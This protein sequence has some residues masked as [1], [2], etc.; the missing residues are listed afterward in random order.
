MRCA[1][2]FPLRDDDAILIRIDPKARIDLKSTKGESCARL[3]LL[4]LST[5]RIGPQSLDAN[6]GRCQLSR[7]SN[8]TVD[9]DTLPSVTLGCHCHV[10]IKDCRS[11]ITAAIH[12]QD[13][14]LAFTNDIYRLSEAFALHTDGLDLA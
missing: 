7:I 14:I 3:S 12:N 8:R 6:V 1:R 2:Y 5:D 4:R 11:K 9:N 13:L 10:G